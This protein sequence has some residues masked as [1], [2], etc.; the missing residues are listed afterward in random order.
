MLSWG[1]CGLNVHLNFIRLILKLCFILL[2]LYTFPDSDKRYSD[3][4]YPC[5][6]KNDHIDPDWVCLLHQCR[7]FLLK[8]QE[9]KCYN[10]SYDPST[11]F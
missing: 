7:E 3:T 10:L 6:Y 4:G 1:F 8:I 11:K 2:C 5:Q 9:N